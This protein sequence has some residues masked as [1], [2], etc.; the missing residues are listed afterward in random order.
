MYFEAPTV[1]APRRYTPAVC[2]PVTIKPRNPAC[3][4]VPFDPRRY[5]ATMVLP[6]PGSRA[7]NAPNPAAIKA[8]VNKNQRLNFRVVTSSVNLLFGGAWR[9]ASNDIGAGE[10]VAAFGGFIGDC[11]MAASILACPFLPSLFPRAATASAGL[12]LLS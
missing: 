9:F 7:C 3:R 8:A 1:M 2:A 11:S 6:W 12:G 5:A 4:A 10:T